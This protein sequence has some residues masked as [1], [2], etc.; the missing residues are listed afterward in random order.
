M[1]LLGHGTR[2]GDAN[3]ERTNRGRDL[4]LLRATGDEQHGSESGQQ[5]DFVRL[6]SKI[7]AQGAPEANRKQ[8]RDCKVT[9]PRKR[10]PSRW[11]Q[12]LFWSDFSINV[13]VAVPRTVKLYSVPEEVV[14]LVP[15]YR[16]YR[17]FLIDDR[18]CIVD[19]ETFEIV[20]VIIIT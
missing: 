5:D 8:Q 2:Y 3:E 1:R 13:G 12:R 4:K 18:I 16:S 19:P 6:V 14:I 7:A 11:R 9:R 10:D 20:D 17:Y 15:A